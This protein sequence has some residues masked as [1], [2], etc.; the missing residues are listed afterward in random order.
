M[1]QLSE[2][3]DSS[4]WERALLQATYHSAA[5]GHAVAALGS[6]HEC[7]EQGLHEDRFALEQC[8]K[9]ISLLTKPDAVHTPD[10]YL[11]ASMTFAC[12]EV[13]L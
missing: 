11:A 6:T 2:L 4:F 1:P 10:V 8:N 9:V 7:F 3:F 13:G 12:L 5:L